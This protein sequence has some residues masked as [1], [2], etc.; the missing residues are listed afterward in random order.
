MLYRI[1]LYTPD[2]HQP[3]YNAVRREIVG[4]PR[5]ADLRAAEW[6]PPAHETDYSARVTR[7][8]FVRVQP[9]RRFRSAAMAR[10][11]LRAV[12]P[13]RNIET[14]IVYVPSIGERGY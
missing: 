8:P 13:H 7:H 2:P 12:G 10:A 4:T 9:V 6:L 1:T 11:E 5:A 14:P 3:C